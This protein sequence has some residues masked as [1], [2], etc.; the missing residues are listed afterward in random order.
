MQVANDF[1]LV[2]QVCVHRWFRSAVG[3]LLRFCRAK[4]EL[5]LPI[6]SRFLASFASSRLRFINP[7]ADSSWPPQNYS[8]RAALVWSFLALPAAWAQDPCAGCHPG[9]TEGYGAAEWHAPDRPA[10]QASE[11]FSHALSHALFTVTSDNAACVTGWS[12]RARSPIL[13]M[14]K[15]ETK[16][17]NDRYFLNGNGD[18]RAVK[19]KSQA[20]DKVRIGDC[21]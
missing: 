11:A 6:R 4:M 7:V 19:P 17:F 15:P 10:G 3:F 14:S 9:E 12:A 5:T 1:G 8:M 13:R 2:V 18:G 21:K 16:L 20:G